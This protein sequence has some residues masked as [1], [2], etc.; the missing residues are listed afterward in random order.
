M[1]NTDAYLDLPGPACQT[2]RPRFC[3]RLSFLVL[4]DMEIWAVAHLRQD[5]IVGFGV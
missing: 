5:L 4:P 3:V 1:G 2:P